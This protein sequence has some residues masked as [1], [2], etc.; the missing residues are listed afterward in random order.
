MEGKWQGL[1]GSNS[2]LMRSRAGREAIRGDDNGE[3]DVEQ[4][5]S[6]DKGKRRG[7]KAGTERK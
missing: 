7:A 2:V 1:R 4:T 6:R 3:I 5:A